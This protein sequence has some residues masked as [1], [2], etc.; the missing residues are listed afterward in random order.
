MEA[1]SRVTLLEPPPVMVVQAKQF[2]MHQ[3]ETG[4]S[5]KLEGHLRYAP[6]THEYR[7][8]RVVR[9]VC[10]VQHPCSFPRVIV[11]GVIA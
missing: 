6:C 4:A 11:S 2:G 9:D 3:D 10:F 8:C 1:T 7:Q 5:N